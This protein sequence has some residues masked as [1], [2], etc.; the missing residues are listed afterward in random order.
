L[1]HNA[2][3][4]SRNELKVRAKNQKLVALLKEKENQR[5]LVQGEVNNLRDSLGELRSELEKARKLEDG[6]SEENR[7][8]KQE[9]DELK[10]N[11][12]S[13]SANVKVLNLKLEQKT[14]EFAQDLSAMEDEAEEMNSQ[15][16]TIKN[17]LAEKESELETKDRKLDAVIE[18]KNKFELSLREVH[19]EMRKAQELLEERNKQLAELKAKQAA[20]EKL[21]KEEVK[22]YHDL[23]AITTTQIRLLKDEKVQLQEEIDAKSHRVNSLEAETADLN[24]EVSVMRKHKVLD[25][26]KQG[27][28]QND[29]QSLEEQKD[30]AEHNL[31]Q[32]LLFL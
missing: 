13:A 9:V 32:I 18:Q 15:I 6:L 1:F 8:V 19:L 12:K 17:R 16:K 2:E 3:K 14:K 11:Y 28:L 24:E 5:N 30:Q 4:A 31:Q 25:K 10:I 7:L 20:T 27:K 23:K 21:L 22:K 26:M 29:L